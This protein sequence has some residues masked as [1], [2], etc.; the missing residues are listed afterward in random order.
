MTENTNPGL[1]RDIS[2]TAASHELLDAV[3]AHVDLSKA[4]SESEVL[5][6]HLAARYEEAMTPLLGDAPS[7]P[8]R[9]EG[10][11]RML[12]RQL[13][14]TQADV[15]VLKS[16]MIGR[17]HLL[18][19]DDWAYKDPLRAHFQGIGRDLTKLKPFPLGRYE[20]S[21]EDSMLGYGWHKL[22]TKPG[23][24]PWRWSGPERKSGL[25][26]PNLM[27][28]PC[29]I[30]FDLQMLVP[31]A[32]PAEG[33]LRVEDAPV[34]YEVTWHEKDK[35]SVVFEIAPPQDAV[36]VLVEMQVTHTI[37]PAK[38][39]GRFDKRKL[40]FCMKRIVYETADTTSE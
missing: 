19:T 23:A 31:E 13:A 33:F 2:D 20:L 40:G 39:L 14:R 34:P 26:L 28:G 25:L 36:N 9:L 27:G 30:R 37:S 15:Y 21:L 8:E 24:M 4:G 17:D 35:L 1:N 5:M 10:V 6:A 16:A 22:E 11:V 29:R 38:L 7:D 12:V 3:E 32:F 18:M